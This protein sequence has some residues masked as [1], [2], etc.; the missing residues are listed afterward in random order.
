MLNWL[1]LITSAILTQ[2][3]SSLRF[4]KGPYRTSTDLKE[5]EI[6]LDNPP[7]IVNY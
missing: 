2:S 5:Y 3:V 6:N 1:L 4:S 7:E